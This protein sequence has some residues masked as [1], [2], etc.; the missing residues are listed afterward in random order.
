MLRRYIGDIDLTFDIT[1]CEFPPTENY[2]KLERSYSPALSKY[3]SQPSV[4][5]FKNTLKLL[6]PL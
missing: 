6:C 3:V 1:F 2:L 4:P 5:T